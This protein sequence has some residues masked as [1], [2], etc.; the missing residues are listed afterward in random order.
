M[1]FLLLEN[2]SRSFFL[3]T[4]SSFLLRTVWALGNS[5]IIYTVLHFEMSHP[6]LFTV[7]FHTYCV[8]YW[9]EHAPPCKPHILF[10]HPAVSSISHAFLYNIIYFQLEYS[11]SYS[12]SLFP[13]H[14]LGNYTQLSSDLLINH[15]V[16]QYLHMDGELYPHK[17]VYTAGTSVLG[18][19]LFNF[20]KELKSLFNIKIEILLL[21]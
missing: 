19:K 17:V 21:M 16:C 9:Q 18:R 1:P 2:W 4:L 5:V 8:Y 15:W 20:K 14:Q 3:G 7:C 10:N 12:K 13:S 11:K 6:P